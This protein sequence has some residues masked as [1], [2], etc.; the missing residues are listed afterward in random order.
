MAEE[1]R[2]I[3]PSRLASSCTGFTVPIFFSRIS[4]GKEVW[5]EGEE[6]LLKP[7]TN[8]ESAQIF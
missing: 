3:V 1:Y 6:T 7:S 8:F 2:H 4:Q 5:L